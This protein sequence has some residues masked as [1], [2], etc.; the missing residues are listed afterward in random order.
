MSNRRGKKVR[1]R[2]IDKGSLETKLAHVLASFDV[3]AKGYCAPL[4]PCTCRQSHWVEV[5]PG[6]WEYHLPDSDTYIG[7][8][9]QMRLPD[10]R[11]VVRA[12]RLLGVL[13]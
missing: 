13:K 1:I 4:Q 12:L 9:T 10:A 6:K 5:S 8:W 3:R 7:A 11:R 2:D